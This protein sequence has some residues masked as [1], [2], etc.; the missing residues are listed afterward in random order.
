MERER[1]LAIVERLVSV[2]RCL[3]DAELV[4][5]GRIAGACRQEFS[6]QTERW[7][8]LSAEGPASAFRAHVRR[9]GREGYEGRAENL[10]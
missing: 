6:P 2:S 8:V 9:L 7:L 5:V 4:E 10:G 1:L 3:S